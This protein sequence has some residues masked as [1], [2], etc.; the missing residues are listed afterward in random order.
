M[1]PVVEVL[2]TYNSV[3]ESN[4]RFFTIDK[5]A[6]FAVHRDHAGA[7]SV[8]YRGSHVQE[9]CSFTGAFSPVF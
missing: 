1:Y 7:F 6:E 4:S 2:L 3:N 9:P 8:S 5:V